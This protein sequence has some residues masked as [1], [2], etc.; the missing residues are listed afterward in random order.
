MA[1]FGLSL[2]NTFDYFD[3][4]SKQDPV[5]KHSADKGGLDPTHVVAVA[6]TLYSTKGYN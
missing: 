1:A 6:I 3:P 2:E 5:S 4:S